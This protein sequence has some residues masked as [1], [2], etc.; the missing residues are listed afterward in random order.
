MDDNI[1]MTE[2]NDSNSGQREVEHCMEIKT[3]EERNN[4]KLGF[5][6]VLS[7]KKVFLLVTI[8]M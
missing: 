7:T 2:K 8:I 4:I 6:L 3:H 5:P 1:Q